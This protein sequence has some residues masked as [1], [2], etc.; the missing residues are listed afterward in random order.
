MVALNHGLLHGTKMTAHDTLA[1]EERSS[2]EEHARLAI[3]NRLGRRLSDQEWALYRSRLVAF[4]QLL[5][6]WRKPISPS[7]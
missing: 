1:A 7:V 2:A 4:F 6:S 5:R 3:E